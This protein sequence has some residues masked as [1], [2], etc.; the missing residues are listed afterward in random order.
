[1]LPM[2][3]VAVPYHG[4][5]E[6]SIPSDVRPRDP[7]FYKAPSLPTLAFPNSDGCM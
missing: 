1:M 2:R 4:G 3:S 7:D 5:V 6:E